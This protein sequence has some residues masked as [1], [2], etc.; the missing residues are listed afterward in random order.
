MC[1][2]QVASSTVQPRFICF[3]KVSR[4]PDS[5][6]YL[7]GE[8]NVRGSCSAWLSLHLGCSVFEVPE[9]CSLGKQGEL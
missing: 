6:I 5:L 8:N 4:S 2:P 9:I 3:D 1:L 7:N